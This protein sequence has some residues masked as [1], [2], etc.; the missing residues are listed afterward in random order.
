MIKYIGEIQ[1]CNVA[2]TTGLRFSSGA[3]LPPH[4]NSD[5]V[6]H[7]IPS[8]IFHSGAVRKRP[9]FSPGRTTVRRLKFRASM[10]AGAQRAVDV[11]DTT[12]AL[13]P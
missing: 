9:G 7:Q 6:L 12:I 1:S 8:K 5:K 10:T 11:S 4:G 3:Q 13:C 2:A